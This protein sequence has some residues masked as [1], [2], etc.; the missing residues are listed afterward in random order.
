MK[1]QFLTGVLLAMFSLPVMAGQCPA[2][3]AKIDSMLQDDAMVSSLSES[4]L[5]RVR[6]LRQK[7]EELHKSGKHGK[8]VATLN[9]AMAVFK[10]GGSS[11]GSSGS[12]Y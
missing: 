2:I 5:E 3:M 8:S 10:S 4:E 7:G 1:K 12:S 9:K 11:A 6:E